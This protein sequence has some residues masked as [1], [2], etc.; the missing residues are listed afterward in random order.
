MDKFLEKLKLT[1]LTQEEIE[2]L[3]RLITSRKIELVIP[4]L[5]TLAKKCKREDFPTQSVETRYEYL[6]L[7]LVSDT[8]TRQTYLRKTIDQNPLAVQYKNPQ[9]NTSK[10]HSVAYKE[11]YI[12]PS[13]IIPGM[14]ACFNPKI[15]Q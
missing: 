3:N 8:K 15:N 10:L 14:Q 4:K 7:V 6:C 12:P 9:Q 13:G 2:N 5:P 11:N 1:K